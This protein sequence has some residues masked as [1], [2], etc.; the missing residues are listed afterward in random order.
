MRKL[1]DDLIEKEEKGIDIKD[2]V[3]DIRKKLKRF[4]QSGLDKAANFHMKI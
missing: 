3:E 1:I 4:R 2:N